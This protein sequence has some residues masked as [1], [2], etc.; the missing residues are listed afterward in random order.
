[1]SRNKSLVKDVRGLYIENYIENEKKN[2]EKYRKCS[3]STLSW[4]ERPNNGNTSIEPKLIYG[5]NA[6]PTKIL[7]D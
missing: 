4:I 3:L 6:I 5:L 7:A 2:K 1:M